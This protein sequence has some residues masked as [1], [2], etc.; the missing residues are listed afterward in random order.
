MLG[1]GGGNTL[2]DVVSVG[3]PPKEAFNASGRK[4]SEEAMRL[5]QEKAQRMHEDFDSAVAH[6]DRLGWR[7]HSK[8]VMDG[9]PPEVAR[10]LYEMQQQQQRGMGMA[11]DGF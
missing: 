7:V 10:L 9:V 1:P 2:G 6:A 3:A 4:V 8:R 11:D 5:A